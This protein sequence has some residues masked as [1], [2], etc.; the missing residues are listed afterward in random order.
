MKVKEF[1]IETFDIPTATE[2]Q[3]EEMIDLRQ[4]IHHSIN[5]D[6]PAPSREVQRK[7]WEQYPDNPFMRA[8]FYSIRSS[9]TDKLIG[10]YVYGHVKET[11]PDY[12]NQKH[13]AFADIFLL[14]EYRRRGY[15]TEILRDLVQNL[16]ALEHITVVQCDTN[17]ADGEKFAEYFGG[18]IAIRAR[19]N[20]LYLNDI[21]WAMV[22]DWY[23]ETSEIAASNNVTMEHFEGLIGDDDIEAYA[24]FYTEVMNQQP[25]EDLEGA[26]S[27]YTPDLLRQ[28]EERM[29]KTGTLHVTKIAREAD[30]TISGMTEFFYNPANPH[31]IEQGLTGVQENYRG[32][33]LGKWLKA[34]MLLHLRDTYPDLQFINTTNANSNAPML[35]INDKLGFKLYKQNTAYK[36]QLADLAEKVGL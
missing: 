17:I 26:E 9:K 32:R 23:A 6:D 5:P 28:N 11:N 7:N 25:L 3:W 35:A 33:K 16:Q 22:E 21:D 19:T 13:I 36:F 29:A 1:I 24:K 30:G 14:E 18:T 34:V 15:G 12:D 8:N 2:E 4:I 10:L 31:K 27:T 20:R